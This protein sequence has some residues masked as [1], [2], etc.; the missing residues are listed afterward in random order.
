M[1]KILLTL[2]PLVALSLASC[3]K[4]NGASGDVQEPTGDDIIQFK[5]PKFKELL[6]TVIEQEMY[7]DEDCNTTDDPHIIRQDVDTNR[8]GEISVNEAKNVKFLFLYDMF[9]M[10]EGYGI[11][12]LSEIKYFT[13]LLYLDCPCN[14]LTT[15]DISRNTVLKHLICYNNMLDDIDISNN[16]ALEYFSCG[17]NK[18]TSVDVSKNTAL[19]EFYCDENLFASIDI[20]RNKALTI[21]NCSNNRLT[22]LD[23]SNNLGLMFLTCDNNLLTEIDLSK[24]VNLLQLSVSSNKFTC[25]D[26]RNCLVSPEA[27]FCQLTCSDNPLEK[28]IL[29][30]NHKVNVSD[31]IQIEQEYGEDIIEYVD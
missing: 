9:E 28:I 11:T 14:K 6:L 8:D 3:G 25:L 23:L 27:D 15:L 24:H 4:D 5:D 18:L 17:G 30:K 19:A 13:S 16:T 26:L 29:N 31:M 10:P 2:L 20:S 22:S 12:D 1:K 7:V 21:L